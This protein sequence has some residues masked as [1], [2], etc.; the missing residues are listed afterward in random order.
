MEIVRSPERVL[1]KPSTM[2]HESV[3]R[4]S[5]QTGSYDTMFL[6]PLICHRRV[7]FEKKSAM[8][9]IN[10]PKGDFTVDKKKNNVCFFV[11]LMID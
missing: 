7:D 1:V 11:N 6:L 8:R 5:H 4:V 2:N 9:F 10:E 3:V